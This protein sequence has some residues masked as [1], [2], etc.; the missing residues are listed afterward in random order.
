MHR[1]PLLALAAA[2]CAAAL[3]AAGCGS[4]SKSSSSGS[5]GAST[6]VSSGNTVAVKMSQIMFSPKT[7]SAKVGQTVTWTNE[8]STDHNVTAQGGESFKSADF[9]QGKSYSY[10]VDKPGTIKYVCTI[11][12][13]MEGTITVTK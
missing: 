5:S 6:P 9:G 12:P 1:R 10:K 3:L 11:H 7:V 4:S 13:G 2:L 8:D